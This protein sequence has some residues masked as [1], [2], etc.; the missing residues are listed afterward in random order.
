MAGRRDTS[1]TFLAGVLAYLYYIDFLG[2]RSKV[3][4]LILAWLIAGGHY[5]LYLAY[6][7]LGFLL[8][9]QHKQKS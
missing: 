6:H 4:V 3:L 5:T 8:F 1:Y 2:W 9:P 7:T